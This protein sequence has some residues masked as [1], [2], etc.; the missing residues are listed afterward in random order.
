MTCK[1]ILEQ[2]TNKGKQC[3][4]PPQDNGYCLKHQ[5]QALKEQNQDKRK[6]QTHRCNVFI[7]PE[8]AETYCQKCCEKKAIERSKLTLCK[9]LIQ[10]GQERG[11][12]CGKEV[13][14]NGY[15]GKHER[16]IYYDEEKERGIKYCDIDRGCFTIVETGKYKCEPC[17]E[18]DRTNE[19]QIFQERK[20]LHQATTI[21]MTSAKNI[22][23]DCGKEYVK[24]ETEMPG[25]PLSMR[26]HGC[27]E[28]QQTADK[29][30]GERGRNYKNENLRNPA[31]YYGEYI[32]GAVKRSYEMLL[33]YEEFCGLIVQPCNYC[34]HH[35][36]EEA[37]G[38]DRMDNKIGYTIGNCVPCC[39][40]CN[41]M[42][43][44]YG[45]EEFLARC[46]RI[47]ENMSKKNN[48]PL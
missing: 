36:K 1:A 26:C 33:T 21:D 38:I 37:N 6:C 17:L 22:C 45:V 23:V 40:W 3:S 31:R 15:C 14:Q 47:A 44:D 10:Q 48:N 8:S 41:V 19:R 16:Q 32:R 7:E 35:K 12:I 43:S 13:K 28:H 34:G 2:G 5:K 30:R 4:R 42:K 18:K 46:S 24:W 27:N 9:A 39:E 29:N 11:R 25:K 20:I